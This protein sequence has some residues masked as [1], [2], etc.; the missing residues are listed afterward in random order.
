MDKQLESETIVKALRAKANCDKFFK[1]AGDCMGCP[2]PHK[3]FPSPEQMC[4]GFNKEVLPQ[5]ADMIES[6]QAKLSV[7]TEQCIKRHEEIFELREEVSTLQTQLTEFR[8][9]EQKARN[10]LCM[11]C[12]AYHRAHEGACDWCIWRDPGEGEN[13]E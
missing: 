5:A 2:M 11:K 7:R 4:V 6:L 9:R 10:E 1:S 13:H 3:P 12:G 8:A